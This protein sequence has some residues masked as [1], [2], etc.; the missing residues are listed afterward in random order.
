MKNVI[1]TNILQPTLTEA[2]YNPIEITRN[3][4]VENNLRKRN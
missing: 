4:S 1:H 3:Y 2:K